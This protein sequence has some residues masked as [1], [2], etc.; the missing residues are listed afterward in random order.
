MGANTWLMWG[1]ILWEGVHSRKKR[2]SAGTEADEDG[3]L[4]C[5]S[6]SSSQEEIQ[7][8]QRG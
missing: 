4:C 6:V 8:Q 2:T 3:L 5:E 1:L 7:R